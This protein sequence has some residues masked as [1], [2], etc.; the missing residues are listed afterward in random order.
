MEYYGNTLD[1]ANEELSKYTDKMEHLTSV[2][3]HYSS[4]MDLL[5]KKQD[6]ATMGSIL[7][8]QAH[9]VRNELEVAQRTYEMYDAEAKHWKEQ[10]D[11]AIEGSDAWEVYKANWEAA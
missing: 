11:S 9:T 4:I 8:G 10:M 3:D 1:A 6:Y 7:E 5:G 2:L